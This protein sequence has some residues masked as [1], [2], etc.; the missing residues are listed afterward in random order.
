MF[1]R[2]LEKLELKGDADK[3]M[4]KALTDDFVGTIHRMASYAPKQLDIAQTIT[5]ET[6]EATE[7]EW[8]MVAAIREQVVNEQTT[9]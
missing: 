9:H 2:A 1:D 8:A 6:T 4:E 3:L 7:K 5:L